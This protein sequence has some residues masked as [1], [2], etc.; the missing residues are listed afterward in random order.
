MSHQLIK[1]LTESNWNK[2]I[3][4]V[5]GLSKLLLSSY[6]SSINLH[7]ASTYNILTFI[8]FRQKCFNIPMANVIRHSIQ[9]DLHSPL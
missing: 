1:R 3:L 4:W 6:Q 5:N 7:V 8:D 9:I 2:I